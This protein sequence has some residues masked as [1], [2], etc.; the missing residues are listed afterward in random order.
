MNMNTAI[1][2]IPWV[3][4]AYPVHSLKQ[5]KLL[6]SSSANTPVPASGILVR[7]GP[8]S[9]TSYMSEICITGSSLSAIKYSRTTDSSAP[10][11]TNGQGSSTNEPTSPNERE[12]GGVRS[13]VNILDCFKIE[14]MK[15][16]T[17]ATTPVTTTNAGNGGNITVIESNASNS[18]KEKK[19]SS[20]STGWAAHAAVF[21]EE[22]IIYGMSQGDRLQQIKSMRRLH[23]RSTTTGALNR[24]SSALAGSTGASNH[25]Q[26]N[27]SSHSGGLPKSSD[28]DHL[29]HRA[30]SPSRAASG[31]WP[32]G[33]KRVTRSSTT[34]KRY[35]S[36]LILYFYSERFFGSFLKKM[37]YVPLMGKNPLFFLLTLG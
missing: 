11:L 13:I 35:F 36:N 17:K 7:T 34:T 14:D 24:V 8:P 5:R 6:E 3:V 4:C 21:N 16:A 1:R 23:S 12:S 9:T 32:V 15:E 26:H 25:Q 27:Y 37:L 18:P 31:D 29:L 20:G 28:E 10:V 2:T 19:L 22:S 33:H 30:K